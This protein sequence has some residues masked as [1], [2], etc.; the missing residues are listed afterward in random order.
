MYEEITDEFVRECVEALE[1]YDNNGC[2]PW[3]KKRINITI[4]AEAVEKIKCDNV[5][6][7][8]EKLILSN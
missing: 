5:S 1:F 4:S 7:A 6:R 3:E 2:F 8:V